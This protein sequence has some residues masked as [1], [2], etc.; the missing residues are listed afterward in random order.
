MRHEQK[1][2]AP[3][4]TATSPITNPLQGYS[5]STTNYPRSFGV[6]G[7]RKGVRT[8]GPCSRCHYDRTLTETINVGTDA[9][10]LRVAI[11][12]NCQRLWKRLSDDLY[13]QGLFRYEIWK[14]LMEVAA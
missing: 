6:R 12:G 7:S 3:L 10:P 13:L 8:V 4:P 9:E 14:D 1:G 11:C 2:P 5:H